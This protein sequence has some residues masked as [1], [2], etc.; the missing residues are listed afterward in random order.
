[1]PKANQGPMRRREPQRLCV[2]CRASRDKR[3]LV[4]LAVSADGRLQ[5]DDRGRGPG[6]GAYV[7][8]RKACWDDRSLSSR[9][10]RALRTSL[11]DED[12]RLLSEYAG[13]LPEDAVAPVASSDEHPVLEGWPSHD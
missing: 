12:R 6:R 3:E 11:N 5:I 2:V 1:M 10:G 9:L 7:C 4:R 13:R 8:R